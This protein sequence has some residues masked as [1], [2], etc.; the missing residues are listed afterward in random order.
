MQKD[1][2]ELNFDAREIKLHAQC[3]D[4]SVGKF[5]H[6]CMHGEGQHSVGHFAL[7]GITK[8]SKTICQARWVA[9]KSQKITISYVHE[10][11]KIYTL[12]STAYSFSMLCCHQW[13]GRCLEWVLAA[14]G[15][16]TSQLW[17]S[18]RA[19]RSTVLVPWTVPKWMRRRAEA[20]A[21]SL[22]L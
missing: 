14:V 9:I 5:I 1:N 10:I 17:Q 8:L 16:A 19:E 18:S 2:L 12:N 3:K 6:K 11:N 4:W 20:R 21:G 15:T 7:N 22:T 13:M